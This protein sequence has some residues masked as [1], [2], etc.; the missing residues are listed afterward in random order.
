M[1]IAA[2]ASSLE[3]GSA[4]VAKIQFFEA[5]AI[6]T[7][8]TERHRSLFVFGTL[9]TE[10]RT[11]E[12]LWG[13]SDISEGQSV[14]ALEQMFANEHPFLRAICVGWTVQRLVW[15]LLSC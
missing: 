2:R 12:P 14:S 6:R 11:S 1:G 4:K 8:S 5:L 15:K 13:R 10:Q 3:I 9:V 7:R